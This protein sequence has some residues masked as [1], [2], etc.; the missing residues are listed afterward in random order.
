VRVVAKLAGRVTNRPKD[1]GMTGPTVL[2]SGPASSIDDVVA[3]LEAIDAR[4]PAT[5]GV[6]C[7]NRMYLTVTRLVRDR[8]S[9]GFFADPAQMQHLDVLFANLYLAAVAAA[10]AGTPVAR[11]WRPLVDRRADPGVEPLQFAIAGMNAHINHDLALAS[12]QVCVE[13]GSGPDAGSFHADFLRVNELLASVE[14]DVRASYLPAPAV[15]DL[16]GIWS[17]ERARDAAWATTEVLWHL[18]DLRPVRDQFVDALG[19]SVGLVTAT[20]VTPV[21]PVLLEHGDNGA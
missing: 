18:R 15:L 13:A 9:A 1:D 19:G 5:D 4:L 8:V 11:P 3:Q 14:H 17:I 6:A 21:A 7:F 20:L 12:T 2:G 10:D 16:V